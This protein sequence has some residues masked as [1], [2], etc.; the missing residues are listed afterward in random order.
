MGW[1]G[2]KSL[3]HKA[4]AIADFNAFVANDERVETVLL[5]IRDGVT[6]IRKK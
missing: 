6:L 3:E 1:H 2:S 5:P 4:Q